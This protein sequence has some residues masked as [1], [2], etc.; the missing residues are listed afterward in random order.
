MD[1]ALQPSLPGPSVLGWH[2]KLPSSGDF[3]GRGLAYGI[4]SALD[5]WLQSGLVQLRHRHPDWQYFFSHSPTWSFLLPGGMLCPQPLV[6]CLMPS[7]DKVGR[8]Y[9]LVV[10]RSLWPGRSLQEE[11]PPQGCWHRQAIEVMLDARHEAF[12]AEQFDTEYRR[13]A[14]SL[15]QPLPSSPATPAAAPVDVLQMFDMAASRSAPGSEGRQVPF[16]PSRGFWGGSLEGWPGRQLTSYWW[17]LSGGSA[18]QR[19][20]HSGPLTTQLLI[21]LLTRTRDESPFAA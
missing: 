9:P 1:T 15:P 18:A 8:A 19:V 3:T 21:D 13:V 16:D 4:V 2:G 17:T 7:H 5:T 14:A 12:S 11:L 10:L 6:G 20:V